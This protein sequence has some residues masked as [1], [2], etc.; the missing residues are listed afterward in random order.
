MDEKGSR[1]LYA[2][3]LFTAVVSFPSQHASFFH[4]LGWSDWRL[5]RLQFVTDEAT[6]AAAAAESK[7]H[8]MKQT[9][10]GMRLWL[11]LTRH[12]VASDGI[13]HVICLLA[14]CDNF[15]VHFGS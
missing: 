2:G 12:Q 14:R 6:A 3:E 5:T 7:T 4:Q 1:H 9:S 11:P 10:D 13:V 8:Q 15:S